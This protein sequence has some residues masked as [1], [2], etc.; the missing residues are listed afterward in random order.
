MRTIC[1]TI[2]AACTLAAGAQ[3]V[4]SVHNWRKVDLR[5]IKVRGE[6]GRRVDLTI[7]GNLLKI[8]LEKQFL[9]HF[10]AKEL[11]GDSVRPGGTALEV[12][13]STTGHAVGVT[14]RNGSTIRLTEFPDCGA[15]ATYF[16]LL[17][18][19]TAKPDTLFTGDAR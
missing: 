14:D 17:D 15:T 2:L 11:G 13:A 5:E 19:S 8:E 1:G 4:D 9:D 7:Y 16:R 3:T 12:R 10:R 6:I 18:R